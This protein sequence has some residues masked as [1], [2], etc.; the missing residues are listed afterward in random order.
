MPAGFQLNADHISA[1]A[2]QYFRQNLDLGLPV[3]SFKSAPAATPAMVANALRP[4]VRANCIFAGPG[5]PTYTI[6][7]RR[8]TPRG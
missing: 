5:S 3:A 8:G 2:V 6:R 1:D 7:N 4:L